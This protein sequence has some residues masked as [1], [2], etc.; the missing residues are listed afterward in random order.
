M[1]SLRRHRLSG[2]D[3]FAR[4]LRDAKR[5][6]GVHLQLLVSPAASAIGRVGFMIGKQH[7]GKAVD[8]NFLRRVLRE[9]VSRRRPGIERFD[10][11]LRLRRRCESPLLHE[12]G[13]EANGL[14]DALLNSEAR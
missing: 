14:L 8:R 13:A 6:D 5:V 7:L 10:I 12:L 3:A 11:V 2:A 9:A 1:G 4:L